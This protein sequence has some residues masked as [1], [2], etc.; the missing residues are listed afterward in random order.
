MRSA[1]DQQELVF[2]NGMGVVSAPADHVLLAQ[3]HDVMAQ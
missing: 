1:A 2:G 3:L